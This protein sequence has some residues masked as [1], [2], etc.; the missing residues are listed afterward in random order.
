MKPEAS[1]PS[2]WRALAG[3]A[4][5][6]ALLLGP[7]GLAP[8]VLAQA[9]PAGVAP[10]SGQSGAPSAAV[11]VEELERLVRVLESEPDR[12]QLVRQ[13]RALI[14]IQRGEAK[15]PGLGTVVLDALSNGV[16]GLT[17]TFGALIDALSDFS[18]L[19]D[20]LQEAMA[21]P[22]PRQ[23][24]IDALWRI[25]VALGAAMLAMRATGWALRRLRAAV[26]LQPARW[27]GR[28]GSGLALFLLDLVP[29]IGF[30]AAVWLVLPALSPPRDVR[31]V[32][33]AIANIVLFH[34]ALSALASLFLQP[35]QG[36]LRLITLRGETAAY[37][38][39]WLRRFVLIGVIGYIALASAELLGL[40]SGAVAAL[41]RLVGLI[42]CLLLVMLILQN[43]HGGKAWL[44]DGS[45]AK[46]STARSLLARLASYWHVL[47]V[48]YVIAVF[49]VW[50]M[51][52]GAGLEFLL[53]ATFFSALVVVMAWLAQL[54]VEGGLRRLFA[55]G[56]ETSRRFPTLEARAN[57]YLP[58]LMAIV[59]VVIGFVAALAVLRAW[60]VDSFTVLSEPPGRQIAV[61]LGRLA[62]VALIAIIL[63]ELGGA[64]IE[65]ML[66]RSSSS[67]R[68]AA[69]R[70]R[71]ML[72]VA[73][74]MLAM[75]IGAL[76]VLM[77][78]SELGISIGPLLAG[79]GIVGLAVGLGAQALVKDLIAGFSLV[80]EDALAVGDVVRLGNH[81]GVVE[82]LTMRMLR[83]RDLDGVVHYIPL[84][85]VAVIENLT[86]DFSYAVMDCPVSYAED[87]DRVIGVLTEV[88]AAMRRDEDFGPRI[89][90][91]LEML[92]LDRF[93]DS[94]LIVRCRF[95]TLPLE[96]WNVMREFNK[97]MKAA[98]EAHK[99]TIPFPHRTL[100]LDDDT[101]RLLALRPAGKPA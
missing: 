41:A 90:E 72:P 1:I 46:R 14:A 31:V 94:A 20:S 52:P 91:P 29:L 88:G 70:V 62:G 36:G 43:R 97:R 8:R 3:V 55:V 24:L 47:A 98:F 2:R 73:R 27:L 19:G 50:L 35:H 101:A 40:S 68:M 6:L 7:L 80:M 22:R 83:L 99:I 82:Q 65:R 11:G 92:G 28:L 38:D 12:A 64:A 95:K 18:A 15:P 16:A 33:L 67:G 71:T 75:V 44:K 34:G 59:Q 66:T 30:M 26:P 56:E 61:G 96:R 51:R 49:V 60:G 81:A 4:L 53:R 87:V 13:L 89:L 5:A 79:A 32:V 93:A 42:I 10:Q 21:D 74:R 76:A 17:E 84:G 25:G 57:R 85:S 58:S 23:R 37:F 9:P 63:W 78:L 77:L 45:Q 86:K 54:A 48:T 69:G 100:V 39:I